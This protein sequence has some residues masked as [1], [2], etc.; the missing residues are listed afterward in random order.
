[1][2][3]QLLEIQAKRGNQVTGVNIWM[4]CLEDDEDV[5]VHVTT[6]CG[7]EKDKEK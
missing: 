3:F 7:A 6:K 1:M 4:S 2:I 5:F